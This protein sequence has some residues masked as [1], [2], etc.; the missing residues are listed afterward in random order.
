MRLNVSPGRGERTK[1]IKR[2]KNDE[3]KGKYV[4]Y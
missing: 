4:F 2:K 1:N 3:K